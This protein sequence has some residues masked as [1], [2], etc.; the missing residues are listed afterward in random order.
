MLESTV[1]SWPPCLIYLLKIF[2]IHPIHCPRFEGDFLK[3][4]FLKLPFLC[5]LDI[6]V[7]ATAYLVIFFFLWR[8]SHTDRLVLEWADC[9]VV[10]TCLVDDSNVF[11]TYVPWESGTQCIYQLNRLGEGSIISKLTPAHPQ[12]SPV[13][14]I[15]RIC[16]S[17][18]WLFLGTFGNIM[19]SHKSLQGCLLELLHFKGEVLGH[20]DNR[21]LKKHTP[22]SFRLFSF[23]VVMFLDH[24][25]SQKF[26]RR[27]VE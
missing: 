5:F 19:L 14:T 4:L 2:R 9:W 16:E 8:W 27:M 13:L 24:Y 10:F 1:L 21:Q 25:P 22:S 17:Q 15:L 11:C 18:W 23:M 7:A 26:K 6:Q 3:V 20:F 12:A